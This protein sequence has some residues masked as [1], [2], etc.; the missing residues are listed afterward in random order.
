[1]EHFPIRTDLALE[2]KERLEAEKTEMRG[3]VFEEHF[4]EKRNVTI[5]KVTIETENGAKSIGKPVGTY[6]TLEA[7]DMAV[8][9]KEVT[10][11]FQKS[12]QN[13]CGHW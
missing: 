12:W 11:K 8:L 5:T 7:P 1:M 3:V 4:D 13:N 9:M 6:L 10:E 2:S